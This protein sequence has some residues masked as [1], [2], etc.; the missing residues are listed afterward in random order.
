[1]IASVA[2]SPPSEASRA[3]RTTCAA[4]LSTRLPTGRIGG[5]SGSV[6]MDVSVKQ[7]VRGEGKQRGDARPLDGVLQLALMQRA[8]A[9]DA[10]R[11]DLPALGDELL[12]HLHV[13]VVDV[14]ELLHAEFANAFA[15]IEE[16]LLPALRS[17]GAAGA[18]AAR[19]SGIGSHVDLLLLLGR[20]G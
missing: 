6:W 15:A 17:G 7:L 14:L 10:A 18:A 1:M 8:G 13:L 9:R 4:M 12:Q 19:S 2:S 3:N 11:K 20:R 16:L 5:A